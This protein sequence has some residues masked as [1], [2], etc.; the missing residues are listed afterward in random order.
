MTDVEPVL[1]AFDGTTRRFTNSEVKTFKRCKRK[2]W[3]SQYRGL[4]WDY[5]PRSG[6]RG[7][8]TR[9][10]LAMEF[11]FHHGMAAALTYVDESCEEDCVEYPE[12]ADAI[13]KDAELVRIMIEGYIEWSAEE[14]IDEDYEVLAAEQIIEVD[15]PGMP[16][17]SLLAK[18]DELVLKRS[19]AETFFRDWKTVA[20][21]SRSRLLHMDEQMLH[22]MLILRMLAKQRDEDAVKAVG[23]V[24]AMFRKVKR[25]ARAKP[26]FYQHTIVRHNDEMLDSYFKRLW[27]EIL[28][29]L[30]LEQLLEQGEDPRFVAYPSPTRDCS[31]DCDFVTVC[32]MFDDGGDAEHVLESQYTARSPLERYSDESLKGANE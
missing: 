19:T 12:E 27:Y 1:L 10:H 7:I 15:M 5:E 6:A 31:W 17:V 25:S 28:D 8:G 23:A 2:W 11:G 16:G 30:A 24:Y 4:R 29:I 21:F 20:D 9:L 32:A 26:P 18:L 22:Y 13:R 14:G 3:L